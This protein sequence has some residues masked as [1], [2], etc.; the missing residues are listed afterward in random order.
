MADAE[1]TRIQYFMHLQGLDF[2]LPDED[3]KQ[4]INTIGFQGEYPED[5]YTVEKDGCWYVN[6]GE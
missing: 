5:G 3:Q 6:L 4:L 1:E 2:K